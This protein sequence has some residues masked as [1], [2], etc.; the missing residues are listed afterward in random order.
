M[1]IGPSR[2]LRGFERVLPPPPSQYSVETVVPR[3]SPLAEAEVCRVIVRKRVDE[4]GEIA[5]R[6]VR[7]CEEEPGYRRPS[8][9]AGP[10]P[11]RDVGRLPPPV[12]ELY[13]PPRDVRRLPR[14]VDELDVPPR[15]GR[16]P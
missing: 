4:F 11:P 10:T 13:V 6:R 8:W 9:L 1:V 2:A 7:I 15:D 12:D 14:P 16:R 3:R 5:V